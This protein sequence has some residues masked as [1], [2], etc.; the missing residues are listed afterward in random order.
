MRNRW[1]KTPGTSRAGIALSAFKSTTIPERWLIPRLPAAAGSS[2]YRCGLSP[3]GAGIT[4]VKQKQVFRP[5][6]PH[7]RKAVAD[8]GAYNVLAPGPIQI[9]NPACFFLRAV[10]RHDDSSSDFDAAALLE[11]GTDA[12]SGVVLLIPGRYDHRN[13]G[14]LPGGATISPSL[15]PKIR[16]YISQTP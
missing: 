13:Q 12:A 2:H 1:S 7:F 5:A 10:V 14:G 11:Q 8:A 6:F 4:M 9:R 3:Y 16:Y 15:E